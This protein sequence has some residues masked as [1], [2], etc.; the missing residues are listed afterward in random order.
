M[1]GPTGVRTHRSPRGRRLVGL[2]A[3]IALM[4]ATVAAARLVAVTT[5]IGE[6]HVRPWIH[7]GR[8]NET[9]VENDLA[10][11]VVAVRGG[12]AYAGTRNPVTTDG[13]FLLVRTRVTA[14]DTR[15]A[16]AHAEL[17]DA[18]GNSY[19]AAWQ[20]DTLLRHE[21]EPALTVEGEL[22]FEVPVTAATELRLRLSSESAPRYQVMVE[23]PLEIDADDVDA[24]YHRAAALTVSEPE[25]VG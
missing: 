11:V 9:I 14:I 19:T 1:T 6:D 17:I 12:R 7:Q 13:L 16:V 18:A 10:V 23:V 4:L 25:V 20:F 15:A 22:L 8:M 3:A 21:I 24:W 2:I 5:P